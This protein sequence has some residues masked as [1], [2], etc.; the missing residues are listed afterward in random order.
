MEKWTPNDADDAGPPWSASSASLGSRFLLPGFW[1]VCVHWASIISII[2]A[3][4]HQ[5]GGIRLQPFFL[6]FYDGFWLAP[7]GLKLK[8]TTSG[9]NLWFWAQNHGFGPDVVIFAVNHSKT[10]KTDHIWPKPRFA[11]QMWSFW[12][13]LGK[14]YTKSNHIGRPL[15]LGLKSGPAA[16]VSCIAVQGVAPL[17]PSPPARASSDLR[18]SWGLSRT[19]H[20]TSVSPGAP[21]RLTCA[22]TSESPGFL[23]DFGGAPE[24]LHHGHG[25]F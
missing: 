4:F 10:T 1:A 18:F 19:P 14:V 22:P 20:R 25:P 8:K 23:K 5:F 7:G 2:G 12:L 9:P 21:P 16:M 15:P 11:G 13:V 3:P 17:P 6:N 24:P